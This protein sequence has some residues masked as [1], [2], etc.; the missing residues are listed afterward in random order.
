MPDLIHVLINGE[1]FGP[2]SE[3]ELRQYIDE[4]KIIGQDLVWN[5]SLTQWMTTEEFLKTLKTQHMPDHV[6][7]LPTPIDERNGTELY[8]Q[9]VNLCLGDNGVIQDY[10][11]AYRCFLRSAE[12][13]HA[14]SQLWVAR[15]YRRNLY[16]VFQP[17]QTMAI[18]WL[19]R[20]CAQGNAEAAKE[21]AELFQ[22]KV[23]QREAA[24]KFAEIAK[25]ARTDEPDAIF[26]LGQC[27]FL[28]KGV[29]LDPQKAVSLFIQAA[30][31]GHA[32]AQYALAERFEYGRGAE[33][34]LTEAAKWYR[35]AA[36]QGHTEAQ[37]ALGILLAEG[38]GIP[39]NEPEAV[40]WYREAAC[41]R[42]KTAQFN[43]A[44]CYYEGRGVP[45]DFQEARKLWLSLADG[46]HTDAQNQLG[47]M[48]LRGEGYPQDAC[49]AAQWF[50]KAADKHNSEA[51]FNLAGLLVKG[52]GVRRDVGTAARYYRLSA[53]RGDKQALHWLESLAESGFPFAQLNLGRLYEEDE[54]ALDV[55]G[56]H[57]VKRHHATAM[58]LI[59]AAASSGFAEAQFALSEIYLIGDT[60]G[61]KI[62]ANPAAGV[63]WLR[64]AAEQG[65]VEAQALL[66]RRLLP[67][68]Q[69]DGDYV[70][71]Y[72]WL[73]LALE[74]GQGEKHEFDSL[75]SVMS[76][77][78]ILGAQRLVAE[79]EPIVEYSADEAP[80][81]ESDVETFGGRRYGSGFFLT[82][83]GYFTTNFHVIR[84]AASVLVST[85]HETHQAK[86]V[87]TDEVHDLAILKL[88]GNFSCLPIISSDKVHLGDPVF[89]VGFPNP[90]LQ[91]VA[92]KL[93]RG[94][95]SSLSGIRDSPSEFQISAAIQPGNSGGPLVT[96]AG[97]V[98]GVVVARLHDSNTFKQT[99]SL[100]QN[101]NYAVKS[102]CLLDLFR[103]VPGLNAKLPS[104]SLEGFPDRRTCVDAITV[105]CAQ[106]LSEQHP[107]E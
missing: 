93:T 107:L 79:F 91:G 41:R 37:T 16:S 97:I 66:G 10:R 104:P 46:G 105:A 3:Q 74:Q 87:A 43:L 99:G 57:P 40:R 1:Q 98:V 68:D 100:P 59:R 2:Y 78:E 103:S 14:Q 42:N 84:N 67:T 85:L 31:K 89:T 61:G 101:V 35:L 34:D 69:Q 44:G 51:A 73:S 80:I 38:N 63:K 30:E 29:S 56:E 94:E 20:A 90:D 32:A 36:E 19:E 53:E 18:R 54:F 81:G 8:F 71:A 52:R 45:Q 96:E 83:D 28:G 106:V 15:E 49:E 60:F 23:N 25:M 92:P 21:L 6:P 24:R 39:R 9:G 75:L 48:C 26:R 62:P 70:E 4:Q 76:D 72:K 102:D 50:K 22:E 27:F 55:I 13:G 65:H 77:D 12:L 5:E 7:S 17:S 95:I 47:V 82:K 58:K 64:R 11:A 86:V 33:P 88:D